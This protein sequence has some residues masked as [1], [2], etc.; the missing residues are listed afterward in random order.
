[1]AGRT[2]RVQTSTALTGTVTDILSVVGDVTVQEL[3]RLTYDLIQRQRTPDLKLQYIKD[4]LE[5]GGRQN[6]YCGAII[7][8][9][10]SI[11]NQNADIW[12][13]GFASKD[14]ALRV[15]DTQQLQDIRRLFQRGV[16]RKDI[17]ITKIRSQWPDVCD[18][19]SLADKGEHYLEHLARIAERHSP[20]VALELGVRAAIR[21]L[22]QDR[23]GRGGTRAVTCRDWV[24]VWGLSAATQA[25]L[26]SEPPLSD[27]ERS[28]HSI[29][30]NSQLLST[31]SINVITTPSTQEAKS[32]RRK[33]RSQ[34][35]KSKKRK[36]HKNAAEDTDMATDAGT[37]DDAAGTGAD[38]GDL[39]MEDAPA[40]E[41]QDVPEGEEQDVPE[42]EE[43]DVPR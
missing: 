25:A 28:K 7:V 21:R 35:A 11:L 6:E 8:E 13:C 33:W 2:K 9:A 30:E 14:E 41:E 16:N 12:R 36:T 32:K 15:L 1:M 31:L 17:A 18:R 26:C 23:T 38:D 39:P 4:I 29:D 10:W 37:V 43:Q 40:G 27:S 22:R 20:D 19:L 3:R 5:L 34:E 24:E 42:G